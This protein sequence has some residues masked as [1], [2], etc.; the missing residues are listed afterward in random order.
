MKITQWWLAL[1]W[2]GCAWA[3]SALGSEQGWR[4]P[5]GF[6]LLIGVSWGALVMRWSIKR[7]NAEVTGGPLAARPVD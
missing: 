7:S 3:G 4:T 5:V 1:V 2:A 6:G